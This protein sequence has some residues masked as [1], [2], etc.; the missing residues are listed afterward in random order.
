[1]SIKLHIITP[2]GSLAEAEVSS[3]SIPGAVAPF[4]VLKDH[5]PLITPLVEGEVV[6]SDA[7]GEHRVKVKSGFARVLDN[8]VTISAEG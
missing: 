2:E 8:V 1:M 3:V 7:E 5:A 6:Y 4:V